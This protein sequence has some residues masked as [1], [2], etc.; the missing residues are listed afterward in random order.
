MASASTLALVCHGAVFYVCPGTFTVPNRIRLLWFYDPWREE[1]A[2]CFNESQL[3]QIC[4][5]PP[6]F[7][8]EPGTQCPDLTLLRA[9]DIDSKTGFYN[10]GTNSWITATDLGP[11]NVD[12]RLPTTS[13]CLSAVLNTLMNE[14]GP[15]DYFNIY[16]LACG[17][18]MKYT[19]HPSR[20]QVLSPLTGASTSLE[21]HTQQAA[22][23]AQAQE[24]AHS[25]GQRAYNAYIAQGVQPQQAQSQAQLI[26]QSLYAQLSQMGGTKKKSRRRNA[27]KRKS[28]LHTRVQRKNIC[29]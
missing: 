6:R 24:Q 3:P 2:L 22:K 19:M 29:N 5:Q 12:P 21:L 14:S 11:V 20:V 8:F 17:Q 10:C 18:T 13:A 26:A 23:Q 28:K 15:D 25:A 1:T 27:I 9:D 4:Q 7:V 16:V